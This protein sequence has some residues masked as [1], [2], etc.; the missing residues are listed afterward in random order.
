MLSYRCPGSLGSRG[1][2]HLDGTHGHQS[3][4]P[5]PSVRR[6][7]RPMLP[8]TSCRWRSWEG[9]RGHGLTQER[10]PKSQGPVILGSQW[11]EVTL[12]NAGNL[13]PHTAGV[14]NIAQQQG[15]SP[16]AG[17]VLSH[18]A[19]GVRAWGSLRQSSPAPSGREACLPVPPGGSQSRRQAW[20]KV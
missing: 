5:L 9:R 18:R 4:L 2:G 14:E 15:R 11:D 1:R 19:V 6:Q 12:L 16:R 8:V 10:G 20:G 7:K 13:K 17:S 3:A